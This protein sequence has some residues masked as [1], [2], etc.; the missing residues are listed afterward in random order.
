MASAHA[1]GHSH[2]H[3][4]GS[5]LTPKG[6]FWTTVLDWATTVDH[7]KIGMM[8]LVAILFMF[9]LG[10][11]AALAV[12]TELFQPVR[13]DAQTGAITGQLL[14]NWFYAEPTMAQGNDVYNI[15]FT[16]HGAIMVFMVIVPSI[17]ASLGNFLLPIMLGTKDVAFPRLN[18]L[19]W[20]IYVIGS[21]FAVGAIL[22]GGVDTGWTF[23]T[24]YSTSTGNEFGKLTLMVMAAFILGFSSILTG[25]NFIV[26]VHKLRAPGMGW[27]DMPLFVWAVYSS[28]IIQ[29]LATPVI[30]IT[31]LLLVFE[32]TFNVGIFDP[33]LGG[34]PVLYQHFFWFYSHP[35]V[36]VM[37]LPGMGIIS[38]VLAVHSHKKIFGYRAIAYSSLGIAAVSFIVWGHH[39][40]TS[41]SELASAVFSGLTFLVAIPTAVK[42]FNWI[43]TLYKGSIAFTTP[44]VYALIFLF[45]FSIGG[46]T[47]LPLGT[48]S[49]DLH[50]HDSYFV[51][52]H[53]HYVMM[54]G[55]IMALMAG[56][57]H[58]W[59]KFFG[60]MYNEN[61]ALFCALIVFVGFNLTFFTQF[62]LGSQ[63]M[64]R[65]YASYIDE[66]TSL[67]QISTYGSYLLGLGFL[68]HLFVFLHSLAAGRVAPQNPWGGLTLEWV[69][70]SPPV[71][72]NFDHD[73]VV[74]HGPY[75]FETT[76]PPGWTPDEYPIPAENLRTAGSH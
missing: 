44:M 47:G 27:F 12:R 21:M 7:K 68:G 76:V 48:L 40:F 41:M 13:I 45:L 33:S 53:F 4:H 57:H 19:S 49:T 65:R 66:F 69:A 51:V 39:M 55:T 15:A 58:W 24:P 63:G 6:G 16:L 64:P 17:P 32:R 70:A 62:Y 30:G 22:L 26:T 2:D 9:F 56:L 34:D 25:L 8:Y 54:G 14:A 52:A 59:P 28:A 35:V 50:L 38:D 20:Y 36:Y 18:L 31:L 74:K 11:L 75:D 61:A 43:S 67:H 1:Q 10:G 5:Y 29:V 46:L 60:R 72:H 42:V 73:P 37:I 3:A 23:Y 71:E